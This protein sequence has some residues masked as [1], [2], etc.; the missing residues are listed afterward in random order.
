MI[1][2]PYSPIPHWLVSC[3][4][5][6]IPS[7]FETVERG[8]RR[9]IWFTEPEENLVIRNYGEQCVRRQGHS[10]GRYEKLRLM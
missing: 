4:G 3:Q 8:Y 2:W 5:L 9:Q 6:S 10:I 7:F 1:W